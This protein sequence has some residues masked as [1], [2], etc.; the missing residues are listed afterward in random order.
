MSSKIGF[1]KEFLFSKSP[2]LEEIPRLLFFIV[3]L[4]FCVF[5]ANK[6]FAQAPLI[7][8][9]LGC[10]F[11]F[12]GL[13]GMK[14]S[15]LDVS[16]KGVKFI[17]ASIDGATPVSP[18][19]LPVSDEALRSNGL[20]AVPTDLKMREKIAGIATTASGETTLPDQISEVLAV[21]GDPNHL[22]VFTSDSRAI[23]LNFM[24]GD[25]VANKVG[26]S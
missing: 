2:Y 9:L 4:Y 10:A 6:A 13:N 26:V 21:S 16:T 23:G 25:Q 1:K 5:T 19:S 8:F 15:L 20:V 17:S 7:I 18:E 24:P 3:S 22:V 12:V 11:A 14:L